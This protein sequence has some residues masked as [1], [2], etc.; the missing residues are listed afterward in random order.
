MQCKGSGPEGLTACI[1]MDPG[2]S[3][4][5]WL[6]IPLT[7]AAALATTIRNAVQ[8]HLVPELGEAGA[9]LI[10]FL[11]ALPFAVLWLAGAMALT[12]ARWPFP[13]LATFLWLL[14]ASL[15]QIG[16][17]ALLLL[18]MRERNFT[19][20][21]TYANTQVLQ[22]AVFA[23]VVLDEPLSPAVIF[24][25][26]VGTLG[27]LLLS[28]LDARYP[29]RALGKGLASRQALLGL[30]CGSLFAITSV[31]VRGAAVSMPGVPFLVVGAYTLLV[32][33]LIQCALLG[34]W[35]QVRQPQ[36]LR[37]AL[38]LWRVSLMAG[39][40]GAIATAAWNTAYA[41]EPVAHVRILGLVELLFSYMVSR[42][43]FREPVASIEVL[44]MIFV[45]LGVALVALISV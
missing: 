22:V 31:A 7:I 18:V 12:G 21:A 25:V 13:G 42:R 36:V 41:I 14:V 29:L 2:E 34:T 1:A 19:L 10:R 5:P 11:Y 39:L 28:P 26:A 44:G 27:V 6:W 17:T 40:T 8:R 16:A 20:G 4:L 38:S 33:Q 3:P 35:I 43:F 24:A 30:A 9:T 45:G 37:R 32:A 15:A 23:L